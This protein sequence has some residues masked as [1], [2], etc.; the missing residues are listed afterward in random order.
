MLEFLGG[1]ATVDQLAFR[2][3]V[4]PSTIEAWR[5]EPLAPAE[6]APRGTEALGLPGRRAPV[7]SPRPPTGARRRASV[8]SAARSPQ[9]RPQV[10]VRPHAASPRTG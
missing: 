7:T 10:Q 2:F 4:Q 5:Q 1:K 9:L 8:K 6:G 3:G